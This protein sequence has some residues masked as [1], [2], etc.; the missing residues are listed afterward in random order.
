MDRQL[1]LSAVVQ[2][3]RGRPA[4][5][6]MGLCLEDDAVCRWARGCVLYGAG[7]TQRAFT[8]ICDAEHWALELHCTWGGRQKPSRHWLPNPPPPMRHCT[9]FVQRRV[10]SQNPKTQ[11]WLPLQ[12]VSAKH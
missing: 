6:G 2:H 4:V 7:L 10:A 3:P 9:L 11:S 8:Q 5:F 1:G 12:S